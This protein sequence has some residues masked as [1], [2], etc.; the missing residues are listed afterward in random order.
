MKAKGDVLWF[1]NKKS[2]A[3]NMYEQAICLNT[4]C[5]TAYLN[6][7]AILVE[8]NRGEE[9]L[10]CYDKLLEINPSSEI[11]FNRKRKLFYKLNKNSIKQ[12]KK[13]NFKSMS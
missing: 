13:G 8:M 1:Q 10:S 11:A 3:L 5:V 12:M 4:K 9:A 2:E 7:A 6:K